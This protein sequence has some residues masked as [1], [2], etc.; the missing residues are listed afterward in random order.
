MVSTGCRRR[1]LEVLQQGSSTYI[2]EKP[3]KLILT[4]VAT[5]HAGRF[6]VFYLITNNFCE[7]HLPKVA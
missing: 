2:S 6:L 1:N 7:T 4:T 5:S 3:K